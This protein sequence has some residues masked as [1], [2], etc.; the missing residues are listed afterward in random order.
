MSEANATVE[1]AL[2]GAGKM[3]RSHIQAALELGLKEIAICDK[4]EKNLAETS[5]K[6]GIPPSRCFQNANE[7][8]EHARPSQLLVIATTADAHKDLVVLAASLGI[9]R[10]LC[11]KPM[12]QSLADCNDMIKACQ[13][14]ETLFA[15]NHQMAFMDQYTLIKKELE[16]E[17]MGGMR[18]MNVVAGCFGLAMNGSHYLQAMRYLSGSEIEEVTAWFSGEK[19]PNPRG[20]IFSDKAGE[21]RVKMKSGQRLHMEISADQG[22]GM[23]VTYG[24]RFGHIFADELEGVFIS[25]ARL[26]EYRD[27][28]ATRY[29]MPWIRSENRFQPADNV[30]PTKSVMAAL[31]AGKNFPTG[32]DAYDVIAAMVAAYKSQET[33]HSA[34]RLDELSDFYLRKFPWA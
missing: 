16:S 15:I 23:T 21:L 1:I 17:A 24:A 19:I 25:T 6:F 18:S 11:E 14:S 12:A 22:H 10:I 7:L 33:G 29:G 20:E 31:L 32:E 30:G 13:D 26:A 5:S 27:M 4:S 3:G 9:R 8:F 28:P 2:I 34:V